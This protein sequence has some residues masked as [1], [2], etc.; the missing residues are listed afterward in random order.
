MFTI[1]YDLDLVMVLLG[2][3][4]LD[5]GVGPLMLDVDDGR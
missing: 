2:T 3:L 4:I 5:V 1:G